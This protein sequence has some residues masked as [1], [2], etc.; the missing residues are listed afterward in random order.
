MKNIVFFLSTIVFSVFTNAQNPNNLEVHEWG[1][2]SA[3]Y[4]FD[5]F[6]YLNMNEHIHEPVPS[7]VHHLDLNATMGSIKV[8]QNKDDYYIRYVKADLKNVTIKM[9]TPILYFY[10]KRKISDL[11]VSVWFP[12]GSISEF[13]P[14]PIVSEDL[15]Y[16]ESIVT[17]ES[18]YKNPILDFKKYNGYATWKL[19]VLEPETKFKVTFPDDSVRAVWSAP[20][21]T[22]ANLIQVGNEVEKYVFY[23]GLAAFQNPIIPTYTP[24]GDLK[25]QSLCNDIPFVMVYEKTKAGQKIIW[26]INSLDHNGNTTF[27]RNAKAITED[28]WKNEYLKRFKSALMDEGLFEDEAVAMLATWND[29]YFE[30]TGIKIFW[31]VPRDFTDAILPIYFN[32]PVNSLVRVFVGRTEIDN[33]R[34]YKIDSKCAEKISNAI[35]LNPNPA[36]DHI[37][38]NLNSDKTEEV[39][40]AIYN[41]LGTKIESN[42]VT[43]LPYLEAKILLNELP[44][45]IYFLQLTKHNMTFKFIKS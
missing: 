30:E 13:F 34:S 24:D 27:C 38:I 3:R 16:V 33:S 22:K 12:K 17:Q 43:A 41:A 28:V 37:N 6:P 29:S 1:T 20:R 23:R 39:E 45:G 21:K 4:T 19:D 7:F 5:G 32:K 11:E 35:Q 14:K 18:I 9:E 42:K 26:G 2:F 10:S 44:K 40:Y 15:K 8:P 36:A 25:I 31:I